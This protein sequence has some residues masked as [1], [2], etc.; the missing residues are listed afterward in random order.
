[1]PADESPPVAQRGRGP[2]GGRALLFAGFGW[3]A[4][5]AWW[6]LVGDPNVWASLPRIDAVVLAVGSMDTCRRRCPRT[7]GSA[8]ATCAR[9]ACAA[10]PATVTAESSLRCL[11]YCVAVGRPAAALT[12]RYLTTAA[13]P[14]TR[15]RPSLPV[16]GILPGTTG[17]AAYGFVRT[18]QPAA[19]RANRRLGP[20]T[21]VPRTATQ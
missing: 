1:M 18:G 8:C 21:D 16:Y 7:C 13:T 6:A 20:P 5:D 3:T 2:L 10:S 4:R 9:T 19:R 11:G 17:A 12:V 15:W 14:G